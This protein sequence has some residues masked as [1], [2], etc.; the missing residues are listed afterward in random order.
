M[1]NTVYLLTPISKTNLIV[2]NNIGMN[3]R[4]FRIK[5]RIDVETIIKEAKISKN[6]IYKIERG[7]LFGKSF[8]KYIMFLKAHRASLDDI[9][10][11]EDY[12]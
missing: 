3:I 1:I 6:S 8:V 9:F 10:N 2:Y 7:Q 12:D 4:V 11:L 5:H